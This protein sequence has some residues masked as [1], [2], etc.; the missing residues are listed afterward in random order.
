MAPP[1]EARTLTKAYGL[2]RVLTALD[3]TVA[4][5]ESVALL[6]PNG[7]GKTTLLRIIASLVRPTSGRVL[8]EGKDLSRASDS[9]R[10]RIGYLSHRTLLY[11][12][13]TAEQNLAFYARAYSIAAAGDRIDTM[14]ARVGLDGRRHDLVRTF[15][16]GMQQRLALARAVLH[17]PDL[18]L[19][20]EPDSGLDPAARQALATLVSDV[21][22]G[23]AT[24][25][26]TT[27][28]LTTA[29]ALAQRIVV[30]AKGRIVAD[31]ATAAL[32]K[33]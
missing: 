18:L 3:L 23:G 12:D 16:R 14:L 29:F 2:R 7:A 28:D 22:G 17:E 8:I 15:S 13:L 24:I 27:H 19:L 30:L 10:R 5:G 26:V 33:Q 21:A 20:D 6:G 32:D 11:D 1:V 31:A 4:A 9:L 25:I